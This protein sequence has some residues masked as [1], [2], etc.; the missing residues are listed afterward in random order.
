MRRRLP[1]QNGPEA[2]LQRKIVDKL[3]LLG[4]YVIVTHG[5]EF[6]MGV[7]DLICCH[8]TYGVCFVEVKNPLSYRFTSSQ[9]EVLPK[10][11]ANGAHVYVLTSDSDEELAKMHKASNLWTYMGNFR[12]LNKG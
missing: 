6:Q 3:T 1:T 12:S 9:Y 8:S 5:N 11:V 10:M 7:P 2:K 4:W